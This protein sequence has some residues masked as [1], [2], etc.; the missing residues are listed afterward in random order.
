MSLPAKLP[1]A[2]S[3]PERPDLLK[4]EDLPAPPQQR[5]SRRTRDAL[6]ASALTLFAER[7]F[8]QTSIADIAAQ[9]DAAAGTFYQHFRSKR[10]LLLVLMDNLLREI[11]TLNLD[12]SSEKPREVLESTLRAGLNA[13]RA[14]IGAY[15]AWREVVLS[16]TELTALDRQVEAWTAGRVAVALRSALSLP[17]ARR[18]VDVET[19]ATLLNG[20]FW[21]IAETAGEDDERTLQAIIHLFIHG[22]F[23][24]EALQ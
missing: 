13:D 6:L 17:G 20:L 18:E 5:R 4:D 24:D 14:Y 2:P 1:A 9:A 3:P 11:E 21:R 19:T 8:E 22:L 12:L 16:D 7:G 23:E 10:Q 15:R